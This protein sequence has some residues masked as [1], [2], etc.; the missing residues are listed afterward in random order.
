MQRQ[1]YCLVLLTAFHTSVALSARL[2]DDTRNGNIGD[3]IYKHIPDILPI[4]FRRI[5]RNTNS[6]K[7]ISVVVVMD[8][9]SY[10]KH[11]NN[12]ENRAFNIMTDVDMIY[13]TLR[14]RIAVRTVIIWNKENKMKISRDAG[15]TLSNFETYTENILFRSKKLNADLAVLI[16]G[17]AFKGTTV[18]RAGDGTMCTTRSAAII[19]DNSEITA[20]VANRVAHSIGHTLGLRHTSK[21]CKCPKPPCIM[22]E[23]ERWILAKGFTDCTR[24][25]FYNRFYSGRLTCLLDYPT[26]LYG[27]PICG[28]GLLEMGE[29]C[30]CGTEEECKRTGADKCCIPK[31]CKLQASATCATGACC[32]DCQLQS[33]GIL[34]RKPYDKDC[35]LPEYCTGE[36]SDCPKNAHVKDARPC[37]S[38]KGSCYGGSCIT[39]ENQ[40]QT[41]WG[42]NAIKANDLCYA[43]NT[44]V[45]DPFANCGKRTDSEF[46]ACKEKDKFCGKLQCTNKDESHPLP[47]FP[48]IIGSSRGGRKTKVV[49]LGGYT[50]HL[51]YVPFE[52]GMR[53]PAMVLSGTRCGQGKICVEH[54]CKD[55]SPLK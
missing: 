2:D 1:L 23:Y 7:Y 35:D 13:Q 24:Y 38:G 34:C 29:D 3:N 39:L 32:Q 54:E 48:I 43:L 52:K 47:R 51:G 55:I 16:T 10:K 46:I 42:P 14:T 33:R 19:V 9:A 6:V 21:S 44:K 25:D 27:K 53:D 4:N 37:L 17:V 12:T 30:D 5:R 40:C 28:N 31:T 18:V 26:K 11:G 49:T 45:N 50:C 36:S 15:E 8:N 41:L 22:E 20:L